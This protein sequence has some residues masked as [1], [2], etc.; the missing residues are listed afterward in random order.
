VK[1]ESIIEVFMPVG[2]RLFTALFWI[3]GLS[4]MTLGMLVINEGFFESYYDIQL[5]L[6]AQGTVL[7]VFASLMFLVAVG[8][9][10]GVR[11]SLDVAKRMSAI[12]VAWSAVGTVLAVYTAFDLTG[13]E[14]YVV[15]FGVVGW[16]LAFGLVVGLTGLRYL[17]AAGETVRRYVEYTS[18]EPLSLQETPRAQRLPLIKRSSLRCIDCGTDLKAETAVCPECGAPQIAQGGA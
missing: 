13:V 17:S 18:T 3:A 14:Y 11:W 16:L 1:R 4:G 2:M 8:M 15:I 9:I 10:N 5:L 6:I 7:L 12:L